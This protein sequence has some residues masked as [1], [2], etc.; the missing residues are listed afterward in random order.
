MASDDASIRIIENRDALTGE[1]ARDVSFGS[2]EKSTFSDCK[3]REFETVRSSFH[4][5]T[6]VKFASPTKGLR[7]SVASNGGLAKHAL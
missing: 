7:P 2:N 3:A 1:G 6:S 5:K 4:A